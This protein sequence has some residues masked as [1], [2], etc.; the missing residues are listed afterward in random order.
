[1]ASTPVLVTQLTGQ[2]WVRDADG[3][4]TPL[5]QGMRIPADAEVVTA[6]GSTVVLQADGQPPLVLGE[7]QDVALSPDV[8]EDIPAAEAAVPTAVDPL[9]ENLIAAIN[10]GQDPLAELDPTAATNAGGGGGDHTLCVWPAC[11]KPQRR[12]RWPTPVP[13][14]TWWKTAWAVRPAPRCR[15]CTKAH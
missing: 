9:V 12:W 14:A 2:A 3:N 7:N 1:M 5:R 10:N 11:W 15:R 8:F 4:L 6:S 13:Q